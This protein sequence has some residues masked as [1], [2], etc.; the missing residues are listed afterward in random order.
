MQVAKDLNYCGIEARVE[1]RGMVNSW[2]TPAAFIN[3]N[4]ADTQI[5][6]LIIQR[7]ASWRPSSAQ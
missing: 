2:M 3:M 1:P 4:N 5:P 6:R 7:E